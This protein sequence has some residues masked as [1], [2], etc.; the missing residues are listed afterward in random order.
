MHT[1]IAAEQCNEYGAVIKKHQPCQRG[2]RASQ[3]AKKPK[4]NAAGIED[5]SDPNDSNF[6]S[7]GSLVEGLE[8][9]VG[10]MEVDEA[11]SSNAEVFIYNVL[12]L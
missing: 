12:T 2:E 4:L 11:Q 1:S 9:E 8:S 10:D 5:V 7:D 3:L 6:M